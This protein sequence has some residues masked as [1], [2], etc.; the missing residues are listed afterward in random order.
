VYNAITK[1]PDITTPSRS[2]CL[3]TIL[4][5]GKAFCHQTSKEEPMPTIKTRPERHP[6]VFLDRT[7]P[8][9]PRLVIEVSPEQGAAVQEALE[10]LLQA[11]RDVSVQTIILDA[12]Q[13][14]V[15]QA[16]FWT[17]E[18][19]AKERVADRAIAEGRVRTFDTMEEMLDFL[20][21]Q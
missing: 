9:Q 20:D 18:W 16:Y 15:E 11:E 17:P 5:T 21:E 1:A 10:A 7:S 19:Q 4:E 12:L 2:A 3:G 14:A 13:T 6:G 8:E